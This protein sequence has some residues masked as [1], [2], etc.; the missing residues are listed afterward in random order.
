VSTQ[1][2]THAHKELAVKALSRGALDE[3][4]QEFSNAIYL[5]P[6]DVMLRQRLADL[7][8]RIGRK[9]EAVLQFQQ[10]AG[11]YAAKGELLRAIAISRTILDL[12]PSHK[13]TQDTLAHLYAKRSASGVAKPSTMPANMSASAVALAQ[14]PE[15]AAAGSKPAPLDPQL[16]D[17]AAESRKVPVRAPAPSSVSRHFAPPPK[18]EESRATAAGAARNNSGEM[19]DEFAGPLD[20]AKLGGAAPPMESIE[21][22]AVVDL[23]AAQHT[24][25]FSMLDE[26]TFA[27]VIEKLELKWVKAGETIVLEG[28]PGDSMFVVV[29]GEMD[30]VRGAPEAGKA[31]QAKLSEGQFFGEMALVARSPRLAT[32]VAKSDGLLLEIDREALDALSLRHPGVER[33]VHDFY[34]DRLLANLLAVSPIFHRFS[35]EERKKIAARFTLRSLPAGVRILEQDREG[36]G[37]FCVLRGQVQA[38]HT[39]NDGVEHAYPPL[40]EGDVFGEISLLFGTLCTATVRTLTHVEV[41][42]LPA[43]AFKELVLPHKEVRDLIDRMARE[44]LAYTTELLLESDQVMDSWLV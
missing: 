34:R 18:R 16:R 10:V 15:S 27:A 30:V 9:A 20:L 17:V 39:S 21:L 8:A 33:V 31:P 24:P 32:V 36:A 23:S 28:E 12:E 35:P 13:E 44:R 38:F 43:P 42:E 19:T 25:L 22:E 37:L 11:H 3:A 4:A 29:Q 40:R 14:N 41:L 2:Q 26:S 1:D 6:R 5:D 7:L